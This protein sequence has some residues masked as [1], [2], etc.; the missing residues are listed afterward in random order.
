[1]NCWPAELTNLGECPEPLFDMI[2]DLVITGRETARVHYGCRGWVVHHN[3][4]LWRGTAPINNIGGQ[5][6]T[7]GAWLCH[8]LWEHYLFTGDREFLARRAYP[9]MKEA[10]LFFFAYIVKDPQTGRRVST[11][12]DSPEQSGLVALAR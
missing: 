1:M 12:A 2:D 4:D 10:C 5:W 3:T 9:I 6:P 8:H 7:G 11:P